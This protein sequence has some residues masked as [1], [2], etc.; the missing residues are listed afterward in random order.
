MTNLFT[1]R[2]PSVQWKGF[3]FSCVIECSH[4]LHVIRVFNFCDYNCYFLFKKAKQ[5]G[6]RV[7]IRLV[8]RGQTSCGQPELPI[9]LDHRPSS[10]SLR[11]TNSTREIKGHV[12]MVSPLKFHVVISS[13]I[14]LKCLDRWQKYSQPPHYMYHC[15][16]LVKLIFSNLGKIW[17]FTNYVRILTVNPVWG[18][19]YGNICYNSRSFCRGIGA[20][21]IK[22][23][24]VQSREKSSNVFFCLE[25]AFANAREFV[26]ELGQK[27]DLFKNR[28]ACS[29]ELVEFFKTQNGFIPKSRR[30]DCFSFP[31]SCTARFGI[32][33]DRSRAL[34]SEL[35]H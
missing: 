13:F 26:K 7:W 25:N 18:R 21:S 22:L 24:N 34:K 23:R 6:A 10:I 31:L 28:N 3:V 2:K 35:D 17:L 9:L 1:P 15:N 33:E 27:I 20:W 12:V 32:H 30:S 29:A 16:V 8:I 14:I 5:R 19:K 11:K 4:W